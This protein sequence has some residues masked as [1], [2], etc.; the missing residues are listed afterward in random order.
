MQRWRAA[1]PAAPKVFGALTDAAMKAAKR[2]QKRRCIK[3]P[4][5]WCVAAS[6]AIWT[7]TEAESDAA[8]EALQ[9]IRQFRWEAAER[10]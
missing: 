6:V 9:Q 4:I 5:D 1:N 10:L 2:L 3:W 7:S 8:K